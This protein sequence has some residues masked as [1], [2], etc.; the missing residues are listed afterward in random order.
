MQVIFLS[1]STLTSI[2]RQLLFPHP[3]WV[4]MIILNFETFIRGLE[5][6]DNHSAHYVILA[7]SISALFWIEICDV[8]NE[9]TV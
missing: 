8:W 3:L 5:V 6:E 7:I 1:L 4:A 2:L 9:A